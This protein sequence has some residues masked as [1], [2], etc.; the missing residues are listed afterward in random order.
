M[1]EE[2]LRKRGIAAVCG[3]PKTKNKDTTPRDKLLSVYQRLTLDGR[4]HFQNDLAREED[5]SPQTIARVISI[6]EGHLGKDAFIESGLEGRK[7][8][9]RLCTKSQERTFGFQFEELRYLSVC[10]D[11][12]SH[13]LPQSVVERIDKSLT[14]LA[15]QLGEQSLP[16]GHIGFHNKGWI[17]YAPHMET[18]AQLR[19]AI[20]KKQI[21]DVTYRAN[22]RPEAGHYRYAPGRILSMSGAL[23]VQGY[24]LAE[25]SVLPER[26]TTF[27]IH[28]I[29][30]VL[31]TGEFYRFNAVDAES[32]KFGLSWHEPKRVKVRF[33]PQAADYVRDRVWS[34]DQV[35]TELPDGGLDL[36]MTTTSEKEVKAWVW[37]FGEFSELGE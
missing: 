30:A 31:P 26:P 8:Y 20:E 2:R 35:M 6:I 13:L 4:R 7:R 23:Y 16:N 17:D 18:I 15:L 3:M 14:S 10:R 22:G 36:E 28:R 9:Y 25:G 34:D 27:L 12:A 32:R 21:C 29:S 37:S 11:I 33:A 5:C 1:R 24:R 19:Q